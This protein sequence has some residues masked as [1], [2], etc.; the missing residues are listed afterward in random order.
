MAT[1]NIHEAKTHL[2]RLIER[3][4]RGEE[5]V[6]AKAGKPVAKLVPFRENDKVRKPGGRWKGKIWMASDFDAL[7]EEVAAWFRG[8]GAQRRPRRGQR[9]RLRP[10]QARRR[11]AGTGHLHARRPLVPA[12]QPRRVRTASGRGVEPE[13]AHGAA[14]RL[15]DRVRPDRLVPGHGRGG[16]RSR[17]HDDVRRDARG[18]DD[19]RLRRRTG[20]PH[21]RG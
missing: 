5:I 20:P 1:T 9:P 4:E 3:V 7:P 8:E 17:H 18:R 14:G 19:R 13:P 12:R 15:R 6:I 2:S 11:L 16:P 21:R 10:R